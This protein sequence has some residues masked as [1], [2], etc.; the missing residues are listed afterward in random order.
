MPQ[1]LVD[2][3]QRFLDVPIDVD[4]EGKERVTLADDQVG[5]RRQGWT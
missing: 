3:V 5:A 2:A 4:K 1:Q